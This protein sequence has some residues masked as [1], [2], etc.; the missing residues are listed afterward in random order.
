MIKEPTSVGYKQS[1]YHIV[2]RI[3]PIHDKNINFIAHFTWEAEK[4]FA[5]SVAA[6]ILQPWKKGLTP[7]D[8]RGDI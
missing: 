1:I 7:F 6:D 4:K 2:M 3:W 8:S 5:N